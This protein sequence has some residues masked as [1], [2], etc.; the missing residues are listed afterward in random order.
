MVIKQKKSMTS[1]DVAAVVEEIESLV[2]TRLYN[3][4]D[5]PSGV[6]FRFKT[7]RGDYRLAAIPSIRVHLTKYEIRAREYPSSFTMG[8]RKYLKGARFTRVHQYRFDRIIVMEFSSTG[9]TAYRVIV[10]L[11][12]RGV[13]VLLDKENKILQAS[14]A[15]EMK[16]RVIKRSVEYVFP[17]YSGI[18]PDTVSEN[19]IK[20][21]LQSGE[22]KHIVRILSRGLGYPGEV[23]E[24]VLGR[25]GYRPSQV[26]TSSTVELSREI[27]EE[28]RKLYSESKLARGY[29]VKSGESY[30]T[31]TPFKPIG[32]VEIYS[33]TIDSYESFSEALDSYFSRITRYSLQQLEE[34]EKEREKLLVSIEKS[35]RSLKELEERARELEEYAML[36]S[37]YIDKLQSVYE[38]V[39]D[40][41]RKKDWRNVVDECPGIVS[42]DPSRGIFKAEVDGKVFELDIRVP[43]DK[44]VIDIYKKIGAYRSKVERGRRALEELREKLREVEVKLEKEK[45]KTTIPPRKIEWY[46]KYHWIITSNGIL[47]IG[48]RNVEQNES[49][50]KKYLTSDRVF[51]HADIHGAPAFVVFVEKRRVD[52]DDLREVAVLAACYSRAWREGI[53]SVDVYWV[54]GEQV[55]KSPPPGEYLVRGAFM[56][57]GKKNY[58]KNIELVLAIGVSLRNSSPIVIVGPEHLV[59]RR[60]LS[61][62]LIIPGNEDATK[63]AKKLKKILAKKAGSGNDVYVEAISLEEFTK[64]IPGPSRIIRASRGEL[65]GR[66]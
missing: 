43:P 53:G 65:S 37:Q 42:I 29:V 7:S 57:Y 54:W 47:A 4:Y 64:R 1:F 30:I 16:D 26:V 46:E 25:I 51:M 19:T 17:P 36:V 5:I 15:R 66:N 39:V 50:V 34:V 14:E 48:G 59:K 45:T 20:N 58:L 44:L 61:Y 41:R 11:L 60:S 13:L 63:I 24:E 49:I 32:L 35:T 3:I 38:C 10:E 55:S 23:V 28:F 31:V 40:V 52:E 62:A 56:V 6:L 12:P 22:G 9:D 21:I 27:A 2:G 33:Y 8:L 18:E